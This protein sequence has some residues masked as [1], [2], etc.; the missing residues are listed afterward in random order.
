[1]TSK[2]RAP[3][4][5]AKPASRA[6][7]SRRVLALLR[8]IQAIH[9]TSG[10]EGRLADF[11]AAELAPEA[12]G[13]RDLS[14]ERLG[15]TVVVWRGMPRL[16][17]FAHLDTIGYTVGYERELVEIGSPEARVGDRLVT[18]D[19]VGVAV[20]RDWDGGGLVYRGP[21]LDL[22][23]RLAFANPLVRDGG[24]FSA[25]Y[26]DNR[27][28]V[29]LATAVFEAS[30]DLALVLT[31]DEEQGVRGALMG[32]QFVA[33]ELGVR[34]AL[35]S[36]VTWVTRHVHLGGGPVVSLRDAYVPRQRYLD[37]VLAAA[38]ASG[39]TYQREVERSG[40]SDGGILAQSALPIDWCFVGVPITGNHTAEETAA[41]ADVDA[42]YRLYR[43]LV[44]RLAA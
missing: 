9:G 20:A 30:R 18:A 13:G 3:A 12:G 42:C 39:V 15:E 40:S 32:G 22:G 16:A 24:E 8:R 37:R 4:K 1:M 41:V 35:I 28:G 38:E 27:L 43:S 26:L 19:G 23:T 21:E 34:Q 44:T 25:A 2:P 5:P 17:L 29:A 36:D 14:V 11:L 7:G 31:S 10:D 6:T 33:A